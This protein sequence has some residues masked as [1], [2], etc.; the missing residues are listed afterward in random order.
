MA[1]SLLALA[2]SLGGLAGRSKG[3]PGA[4]GGAD[5]SLDQRPCTAALGEGSRLTVDLSPRPV[6]L[7]RPL[8]VV[9]VFE[10]VV[11][12]EVEVLFSSETMDMGE[13]P[14]VLR[15]A[16]S[17]EYVGEGALPLCL[18]AAMTWRADVEFNVEGKRRAF[19]FRFQAGPGAVGNQ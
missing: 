12:S 9:A 7:A 17:G 4:A 14:V 8:R 18:T 19:R 5:C 11:P 3:E 15:R 16:P 6:P 10:G 1:A 2:L 13:T